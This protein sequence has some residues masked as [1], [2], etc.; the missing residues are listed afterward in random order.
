MRNNKGFTLVEL[1]VAIAILSIIAVG[2]TVL[3][4]SGSSIY[5]DTNRTI[6]LQYD[7]QI[8]NAQIGEHAID[9]NAGIVIDG[10]NLFLANLVQDDDELTK[11]EILLKVFHHSGS[12]LLYAEIQSS[13]Y[14][15]FENIFPVDKM[16][17]SMTGFTVSV[18]DENKNEVVNNEDEIAILEVTTTLEQKEK[19]STVEHQIALRNKPLYFN[20]LNELLEY[21]GI[22]NLAP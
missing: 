18:L 7:S 19:S 1:L 2:I 8:V 10:D 16:S 15:D 22:S 20:S 3:M 6:N 13:N 12:S 17:N 21:F 11:D 4:S 5:E 14:D 9:C